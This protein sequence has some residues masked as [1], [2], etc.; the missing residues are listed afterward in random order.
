MRFSD[1][2]RDRQDQKIRTQGVPTRGVPTL[3][4]EQTRYIQTRSVQKMKRR[5]S[6]YFPKITESDK[7]ATEIL[8]QNLSRQFLTPK[9]FF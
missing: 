9:A 1:K 3:A 5:K 2:C 4:A 6:R 7:N 8:R